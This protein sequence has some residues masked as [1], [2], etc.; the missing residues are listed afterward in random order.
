MSSVARQALDRT[1]T[2]SRSHGRSTG[3]RPRPGAVAPRPRPPPSP[4]P[5]RRAGRIG[6]STGSCRA[7]PHSLPQLT[8]WRKGWARAKAHVRPGREARD[9][10]VRPRVWGGAREAG[11]VAG[12]GSGRR[13]GAGGGSGMA[14]RVLA[15]GMALIVVTFSECKRECVT[16]RGHTG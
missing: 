12:G 6:P 2:G 7:A 1:S 5:A 8:R 13:R 9:R 16:V 4:T 11:R 3:R 15:L 14:A 10:L